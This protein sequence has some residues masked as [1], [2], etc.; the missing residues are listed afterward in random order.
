MILKHLTLHDWRNYD[1][2]DLDFDNKLTIIEGLNGKGKT[3]LVEAVYYLSLAHS[4]RVSDERALI[5]NG[6]QVASITAS[7]VEGELHRTIEISL[8]R[9]SKK[10]AINGKPIHRLSELSKLVNVLLFS[11]SDVFLFSG[12]PAERRN[13]LD[14]SLSKQSNDYFS[15]I[16]KYNRL[17][18]DR[19]AVLK[20]DGTNQTYLEVLTKQLIECEEPL[21]NYRSTYISKLNEVVGPLASS[22]YGST[23]SLKLVYKPFVTPDDKFIAEATK[24]YK[25]ALESDLYHKSTSIGVHRED[26]TLLLDDQDIGVYGSQGENRLAAIALKISPYYLIESEERKPITVLDDVYSELDEIH[27]ERLTS[28]LSQLGQTFVTATKLTYNGASH[29]EVADHKATR[30]I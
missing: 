6:S 10:I 20:K 2:L 11:P 15:L 28:L 25:K 13:F 30:R 29:I 21:I 27:A 17:L 12:S 22:L 4:W 18:A 23:R 7:V 24:A 3:N 9:T 5:R 16:G 1:F 19:N 8:S 26:F 14:V